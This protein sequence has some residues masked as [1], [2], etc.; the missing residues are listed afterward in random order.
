M[1]LSSTFKKLVPAALSACLCLSAHAASQ[2][3]YTLKLH[4]LLPPMS[5]VH[6]Q[7]LQPWADK[8]MKESGGRIKIDIYPS[9]Q[10][11]G[12]PQQLLDQSRT[13]VVDISW[14]V[15]GYT[16][17]RFPKAEVFE[18]PFMAASAEATSQAIQT[19]ANEEMQ[20]DF[21]EFKLLAIHTNA[22]G[23]M[24]SRDKVIR[25]MEDLKDLKVRAPNKPIAEVLT[26][27]GATP[28]FLPAPQLP[29]ALSKG[30]LD[31]AALSWDVVIP[32]K[33]H[34]LVKSHTELSGDRG[35]YGQVFLFTMNLDTYQKLPADLQQVIN[36]NSGL[37][38]AQWMGKQLDEMGDNGRQ[39]TR[40][41]GNEMVRLSDTET[42]RWKIA[43]QPII[44][45]WI[46][47]I[48]ADGLDGQRLYNRANA[49]IEQYSKH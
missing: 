25:S 8:V 48:S 32:F 6:T 34:E 19:Y 20:D 7:I 23:V 15:A 45:N 17:G 1:K 44:N 37:A 46:D 35:L 11:G 24:H 41:S 29:S 13:G 43:S 27:M 21:K 33:I 5:E 42:N 40:Q 14:T 2:P 26:M 18:L 49:L 16:P 22:T 10:L 31:V 12:K 36:N 38:L 4:H 9:M 39:I 3:Q 30:V 47:D 28:V